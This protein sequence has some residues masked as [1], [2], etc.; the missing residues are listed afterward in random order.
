MV[1]SPDER[2]D[3]DFDFSRWLDAG[4]TVASALST[5]TGTATIDLQ[6]VSG[7][8]VKLWVEGGADGETC[9]VSV[10][11]TTTH[12]RVKEACLRIRIKDC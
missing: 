9:H 6:E 5:I 3:Y 10:E 4:D 2:L 8:N 11:A 1:K 7:T 12:G